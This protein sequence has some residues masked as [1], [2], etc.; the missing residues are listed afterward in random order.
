MCA[1]LHGV[2]EEL[3]ALALFEA[4]EER[5]APHRLLNSLLGCLVQIRNHVGY[6]QPAWNGNH[7]RSGHVQSADPQSCSTWAACR[8]SLINFSHVSLAGKENEDKRTGKKEIGDKPKRMSCSNTRRND[9][10]SALGQFSTSATVIAGCSLSMQS[11]KT[12]K[13]PPTPQTRR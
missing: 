1:H 10:G 8:R 13:L 4:A 2:N 9:T 11:T 5:D 6:R 12:H 3:D 7:V